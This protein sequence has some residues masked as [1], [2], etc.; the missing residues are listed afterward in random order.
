MNLHL[1]SVDV[2]CSD[3]SSQILS[4]Y[5]C[6]SMKRGVRCAFHHA[7][8]ADWTLSGTSVLNNL[9][10]NVW[11][12]VLC[13]CDPANDH[14]QLSEKTSADPIWT[15]A[16][17]LR[18]PISKRNEQL[19]QIVC[20]VPLD[21]LRFI[22][23]NGWTGDYE[24]SFWVIGDDHPTF[25]WILRFIGTSWMWLNTST[26]GHPSAQ[27]TWDD[28]NEWVPI[29]PK[30]C[31]SRNH[32]ANDHSSNNMSERRTWII[33]LPETPLWLYTVVFKIEK[34]PASHL[35]YIGC[36]VAPEL[37]WLC[38]KKNAAQHS[39]MSTEPRIKNNKEC[40]MVQVLVTTSD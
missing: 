22:I 38:G 24:K 9:R 17:W 14:C 23:H 1:T 5:H 13:R 10:K 18:W 26:A 33:E 25:G 37:S 40:R 8:A 28:V 2:V 34:E 7:A 19:A 36:F 11:E 6:L 32:H 31:L 21:S 12:G 20:H 30:L 35:P 29:S 39:D 3:L 4:F 15:K 16:R 27:F